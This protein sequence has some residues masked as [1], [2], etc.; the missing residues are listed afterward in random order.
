VI[1]GLGHEKD[2]IV[3]TLLKALG[4]LVAVG[5]IGVAVLL[6]L[7]RREHGT[8]I[9]LP[10]PTGPLPVGRASDVWVNNEQRDDLG[11]P[12]EV[13]NE[14]IVWIWYPSAPAP[15]STPSEYLPAPW[16]AALGQYQSLLMGGL[17]TRDPSRVRVHSTPDPAVSPA[18]A[19]YPVVIM[20]PGLGA[21]TTDFTTLAEDLASHGYVVVGFDAP[22]RTG[23]VV[24]PDGR[25]VRRRPED[26]PETLPAAERDRL[27]ERLMALWCADVKFIV[28][29]L[30]ELNRRDPS[31]RFKGRLDLQRI[32][33]FGHSLGGAVAA[34]FCHDDHRCKAGIDIDG[35]L[36]G[37]VIREGLDRPFM[38]ILSDHGDASD[39]VSRRILGEIRSLYERLPPNGRT[40]ITLRGAHHFSF[41]DQA[42]LKSRLVMRLLGRLEARRGLTITADYV[43]RFFDTHL[44][45]TSNPPPLGPT[46]LYPEVEIGP[47]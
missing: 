45:A 8:E 7:L 23:L 41:G 27:V 15:G 14:R 40:W 42:L 35:A 47:R 18:E 43:H 12:Q 6:G 32:G 1:S 3:R 44:K 17:L 24:L 2:R 38:F 22:Y 10:A 16:R 46:A 31:G 11:P 34:Q 37:S 29:H 30:E 13:H 28:D 36:H 39:P 4:V 19:A 9:A 20:R 26:N 33:L 25:I 5:V 21:L